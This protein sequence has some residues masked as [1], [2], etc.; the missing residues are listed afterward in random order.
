VTPRL[1][2][3]DRKGERVE[4]MEKGERR[5]EESVRATSNRHKGIIEVRC[6]SAV[7]GGVVLVEQV[8]GAIVGVDGSVRVVH[9]DK[10]E[11]VTLFPRT[12]ATN[13]THSS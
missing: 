13:E 10:T 7:R 5:I 12:P 3:V 4:E 2:S 8:V 11:S 9:C 6:Y 1:V